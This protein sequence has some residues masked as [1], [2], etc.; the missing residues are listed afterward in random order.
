MRL[1]SITIP[2][3]Q[4]QEDRKP[5]VRLKLKIVTPMLG[6]GAI[7]GQPSVE[8]PIRGSAIRG[9]LRYWWRATYG[10]ACATPEEM[11]RL[12]TALWGG[13]EQ[14]GMRSSLLSVCIEP[15][16]A[17]TSALRSRA[18]I[19]QYAQGMLTGDDADQQQVLVD[20]IF[21][22]EIRQNRTPID[23][24]SSLREQVECAV[25]SLVL[26]G[27]L[28]ARTRRGFGCLQMICDPLNTIEVDKLWDRFN[29]II[30]KAH[31]IRAGGFTN[32]IQGVILGGKPQNSASDAWDES[33]KVLKGFRQG[34]YGRSPW[35]ESDT[36]RKL[37][38]SKPLEDDPALALPRA[39]LGLPFTVKDIANSRNPAFSELT[40][41]G[42][43]GSQ[44]LASPVI[45]KPLRKSREW[46]P[47]IIFLG[48][49]DLDENLVSV[50]SADGGINGTMKELGLSLSAV[51]YPRDE[52]TKRKNPQQGQ[53]K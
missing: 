52:S 7:A 11:K 15:V 38:R 49:S 47:A 29:E 22:L 51:G 46:Y 36:A 43:N 50:Q 33:I 20:S 34:N 28:G 19:P 26:F 16:T 37:S 17:G 27:G 48:R 24:P 30:P 35:P 40:V 44:R 23:V 1:N 53:K 25:L 10:A 21:V 5:L 13:S 41:V 2:T 14:G 39:S 8:F 12:E 4:P 42:Y 9:G 3:I 45:V 6:G 18:L 32:L 31:Q